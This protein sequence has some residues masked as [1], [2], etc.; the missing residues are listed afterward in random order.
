[1]EGEIIRTIRDHS[2]FVAQY[3]AGGVPG[4][5]EIGSTQE[6]YCPTMLATGYEGYVGQEFVPAGDPVAALREAFAACNVNP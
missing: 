3:H 1:M 4:R 2:P 5:H 6:L